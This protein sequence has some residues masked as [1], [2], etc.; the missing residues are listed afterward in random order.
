ML[1]IKCFLLR[2]IHHPIH[3]FNIEILQ[4]ILKPLTFC[5]ISRSVPLTQFPPHEF[6]A[7]HNEHNNYINYN[8]FVKIT[9]V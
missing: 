8:Y 7:V 1:E 5:A 2:V 6:L 9:L 4:A 3:K